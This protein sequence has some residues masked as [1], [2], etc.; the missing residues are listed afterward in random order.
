MLNVGLVIPKLV[1]TDIPRVLCHST[2]ML[3]R[4]HFEAGD[5][6]HAGAGFPDR[7][8]SVGFKIFQPEFPMVELGATAVSVSLHIA[9]VL[10]HGCNSDPSSRALVAGQTRRNDGS[11]LPSRGAAPLLQPAYACSRGVQHA[12]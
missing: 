9:P 6:L 7:A 10:W 5:R 2:Q 3:P 4:V 1:E 12:S 8:L 11:G